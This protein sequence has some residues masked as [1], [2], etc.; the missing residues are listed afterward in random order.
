VTKVNVNIG[1]YVNP[2]DVLF[3]IVNPS[4]IHLA[5]TVFEKD[6][7]KLAVG[8]KLLAYTN[9]DPARK[10]PC[11]IILIGKDF[12]GDKSIEVH[13]HF[14]QFDKA[15]IPGMFMNGD[16]RV[17]DKQ[18]AALPVPAIVS[19]G[20]KE[21]AFVV[22]GSRQFELTEVKTGTTENGYT[23]IDRE[24]MP[25]MDSTVFVTRGAYALLM[26]MKNTSQEDE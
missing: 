2:S 24:D 10:Y 23:A 11:T 7:N 8:Q 22:K 14:Q 19:Y 5:L 13:C 4:D 25:G 18:V 3:E 21:Y 15:L 20:G 17:E 6:V 16:V 9:N 26:K 1:K 12:S